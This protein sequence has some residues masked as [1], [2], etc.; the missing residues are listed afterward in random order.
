MARMFRPLAAMWYTWGKGGGTAGHESYRCSDC[1][2]KVGG[3][4]LYVAAKLLYS[5][6]RD[7]PR[8]QEQHTM[9]WT[10]HYATRTQNMTSSAIREL[11][12]LCEQPD[13]ISF[14]GGLPV[15]EVFPV[16]AVAVVSARIL[17]EAGPQALQYGATEGYR[18][19]RALLAEE[20]GEDGPQVGLDNVL[21]TTGSQQAIDLI[22]KIF[23]NRGDPVVVE[24]PTYL[25]ALQA[26]NAYGACYLSVTADDQGMET[27]HLEAL[28]AEQPKL[29]YCLPNFQNPSG[30]TLSAGRREQLV[31][32]ARRHEVVVVE[33]DPYRE[34]RFEG[35]HL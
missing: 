5:E 12:K 35:Q 28:M 23:I 27:D 15:P 34:V 1:I 31:D 13:F 24:S 7:S 18:P 33:D 20:L 30:V 6:E 3:L 17:R 10:R 21:I 25:A 8:T 14:A 19:L 29:V 26:W 16:E 9:D 32:I 2:C 11:L 4:S 22:G